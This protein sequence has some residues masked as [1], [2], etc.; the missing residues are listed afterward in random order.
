MIQTPKIQFQ[1]LSYDITLELDL[2]LFD[3]SLK[4]RSVDEIC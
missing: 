4:N 1:Y 2:V 3:E